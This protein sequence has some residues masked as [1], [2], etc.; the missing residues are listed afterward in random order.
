MHFTWLASEH[1][2]ASRKYSPP[3]TPKKRASGRRPKSRMTCTHTVH[4]GYAHWVRAAWKQVQRH[5]S[6][7]YPPPVAMLGKDAAPMA[8]GCLEEGPAEQ[9]RC[10]TLVLHRDAGAAQQQ[11]YCTSIPLCRAR[12]K[13]SIQRV[14]NR[15]SPVLFAKQAILPLCV[16]A[17]AIA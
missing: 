6:G 4:R 1:T 15:H 9:C 12:L 8:H 7:Q 14:P 11:A 16:S 13:K 3:P 10:F 5:P 17:C 2:S